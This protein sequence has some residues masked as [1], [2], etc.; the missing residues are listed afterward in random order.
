MTKLPENQNQLLE[1]KIGLIFNESF[2][3]TCI[4]TLMCKIYGPAKAKAV[5]KG[6]VHDEEMAMLDWFNGLFRDA[7]K[8]GDYE[9]IQ[10][11]TESKNVDPT[12]LEVLHIKYVSSAAYNLRQIIQHACKEG[13]SPPSDPPTA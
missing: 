6:V 9:V 1:A 11:A 8:S 12:D 10:E 7:E 2:T 13:G 4:A 5:M 3:M